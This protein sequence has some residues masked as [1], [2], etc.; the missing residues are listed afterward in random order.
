V[1]VNRRIKIRNSAG[2]RCGQDVG[3]NL[4]AG[5]YVPMGEGDSKEHRVFSSDSHLFLK[6]FCL[7]LFHF[8]PKRSMNMFYNQESINI[9][10]YTEMHYGRS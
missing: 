3:H 2:P 6:V 1:T 7:F 4:I 8:F 9:V 10:L 5:A